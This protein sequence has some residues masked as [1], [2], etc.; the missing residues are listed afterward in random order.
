M[1]SPMEE[2]PVRHMILRAASGR[3]GIVTNVTNP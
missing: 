1:G 2:L 3:R